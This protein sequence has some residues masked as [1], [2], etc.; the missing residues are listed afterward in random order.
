MPAAL[1]CQHGILPGTHQP[2]PPTAFTVT[3]LQYRISFELTEVP[4][5]DILGTPHIAGNLQPH[6]Q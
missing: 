5:A 2:Q 1:Q 3:R 6:R 4:A